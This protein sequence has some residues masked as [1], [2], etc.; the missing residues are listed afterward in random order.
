MCVANQEIRI[1]MI[2][3]NI[4]YTFVPIILTQFNVENCSEIHCA[5]GVKKRMKFAWFPNI[6]FLL[7]HKL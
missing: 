4:I 7:N 2:I 5:C 3:H 1:T 6:Y